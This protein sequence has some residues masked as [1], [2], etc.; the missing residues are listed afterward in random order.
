MNNWESITYDQ[1]VRRCRELAKQLKPYNFTKIVAVTRGGMVPAAL[2]AQFLDIRQIGSIALASYSQKRPDGKLKCLFAANFP[3]DENTLFVDDL[4]DSGNTYRYLKENY[5]A[6]KV[7]VLYNKNAAVE[8][9]FAAES[10]KADT[11]LVFP[12]EFEPL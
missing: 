8:L 10:K 9:D 12:W 2:L 4:Y 7:A 3:A 11:W 1:I 5:P 6:A